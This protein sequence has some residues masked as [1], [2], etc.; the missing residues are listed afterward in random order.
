MRIMKRLIACLI[1]L[2]TASF[3]SVLPAHSQSVSRVDPTD[4]FVGMKDSSLQLMIYGEG[5][6]DASIKVDYPGVKVDSI[7]RLDSKSYLLVYL[8]V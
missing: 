5:V 2:L 4:W 6:G 7:V 8:N 1:V 3:G